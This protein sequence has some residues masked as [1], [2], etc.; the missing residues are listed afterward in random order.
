M[1][2]IFK[3]LLFLKILWFA[4]PKKIAKLKK[5]IYRRLLFLN[6]QIFLYLLYIYIRNP[7]LLFIYFSPPPAFLHPT[8]RNVDVKCV[9]I[10]APEVGFSEV[11]K[12]S[13]VIC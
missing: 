3:S 2:Y 12:N 7:S 8:M 6:C 4:N 1:T 10:Y 13:E 5:Y 11:V 9:Y